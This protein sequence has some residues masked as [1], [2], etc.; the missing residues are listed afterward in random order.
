MIMLYCLRFETPPNLEGH[1]PLFISPQEH[2]CPVKPQGTV[3]PFRR[4]G[5][6]FTVQ[7]RSDSPGN[8]DVFAGRYQATRVP[9][10]DRYNTINT[11]RIYTIP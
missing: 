1:V 11:H 2:C 4:R 5:N 3:F 9:S 7:L 6:L 8:D 10:R